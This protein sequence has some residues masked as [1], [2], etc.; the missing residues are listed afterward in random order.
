MTKHLRWKWLLPMTVLL[1]IWSAGTACAAV[2]PADAA[3][4]KRIIGRRA[5]ETITAWRNKDAVKLSRLAHPTK[6]IRF[7][8]YAYVNVKQDMVRKASQM[9]TF[10]RTT[11]RYLWGSYDGSGEPIDLTPAAYYKRFIYEHDFAKAK[12]IGYNKTL[13][14]G[15]TP[16]NSGQVYPGATIVEYHFPGFDPQYG[17]MD[18]RSLRLVFERKGNVWYLVGVIHAEWTI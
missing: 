13:G 4:L 14:Q 6:G 17:G 15:N 7:S 2:K 9:R 11:R 16:H 5:T 8:P 3:A 10:F 1:I 12:Q 18:W